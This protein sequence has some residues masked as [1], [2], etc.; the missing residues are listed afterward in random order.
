M[1]TRFCH[2]RILQC[3]HRPQANHLGLGYLSLTNFCQNYKIMLVLRS[4]LQLPFHLAHILKPWV[5]MLYLINSTCLSSLLYV[6]WSWKM[7]QL[8]LG[9]HSGGSHTVSFRV[10]NYSYSRFLLEWLREWKKIGSQVQSKQDVGKSSNLWYGNSLEKNVNRALIWWLGSIKPLP[11][12]FLVLLPIWD[13]QYTWPR[14]LSF[15]TLAGQHFNNAK[16]PWELCS[17]VEGNIQIFSLA[18]SIYL[19][20]LL[21]MASCGMCFEEKSCRTRV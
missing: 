7:G 1:R 19:W 13:P 3:S 12:V 5:T 2:D 4:P 15:R 18:F 21:T 17:L 14:I 6:A 10:Q 20:L 16:M 8:V 11:S 9:F